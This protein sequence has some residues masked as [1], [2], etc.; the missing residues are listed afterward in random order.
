[1]YIASNND[2]LTIEEFFLPF[3][4]KLLKSN[5]WVKLAAMMPWERIEQ[6]YMASFQSENGRPA[7][8]AR[9]AFGAIFIKEHDNLTDAGTVSAI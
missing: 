5:R 4:G 2:Q 6:I 9:I 8:P 3:G 7:L 1:M